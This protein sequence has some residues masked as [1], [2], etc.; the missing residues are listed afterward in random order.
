MAKVNDPIVVRL[1][2]DVTG[3]T[4]SFIDVGT[5]MS[6]EIIEE[7]YG[8][9]F[10][11]TK[12][13]NNDALGAY[14]IGSKTPLAYGNGSF[15]VTTRV[16]G[17]EYGYSIYAGQ[18]S[19]EI[20]LMYEKPTT[21]HNGTEV[22]V[23][24]IE[25]DLSMFTQEIN[26]QLYYFD[27]IIFEGFHELGFKNIN[28]KYT[29]YHGK[30]F[31]YRTD[32]G[33]SLDP[34]IHICIGRV[35]Y[36]INY[37]S[38]GLSS[39]GLN[40]P[41]A[42]KANIGDVDVTMNREALEYNESTRDFIIKKID[43]I[44]K[45]LMSMYEKQCS[46]IQTVEDYL[47]HLSGK[48]LLKIRKK[49]VLNIT[50]IIYNQ[51]KV[52]FANFKYDLLRPILDNT[53]IIECFYFYRTYGQRS[54]KYDDESN[55]VY[56]DTYL[57]VKKL[58]NG[59]SLQKDFVR[60]LIKQSYLASKHKRFYVFIKQPY[61]H[62]MDFMAETIA[63][64]FGT[65][66]TDEVKKEI[67]ALYHE[68]VSY[69]ESYT[70]NYDSIIVPQAFIDLKKQKNKLK[71]YSKKILKVKYGNDFTGK[72]NYDTI[73]IEKLSLFHGKIFYG[74]NDENDKI[75]SSHTIFK[76][77]F[78]DKHIAN[79]YDSKKT[80][81]RG[82]MFLRTNP[83]NLKY[84][85]L[86]RNSYHIDLFPVMMLR[87]KFTTLT[88][89]ITIARI[90]QQ[91]SDIDEYLRHKSFEKIDTEI[92]KANQTVVIEME[93]LNKKVVDFSRIRIEKL[94]SDLRMTIDSDFPA[95]KEID[96]LTNISKKNQPFFS[97]FNFNADNIRH[98]NTVQ[99]L[100]KKVLIK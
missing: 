36:P 27:N 23:P 86:L 61:T 74:T 35:A 17:I 41:I 71:E 85:K 5:G 55:E 90:K 15:F 59:Y 66:L 91:Y 52:K 88:E 14:G 95:Q 46:K 11:S 79:I 77:V 54:S 34:N 8:I 4:L 49:D 7:V 28:N 47:I 96:Y 43:L 62:D 65:T 20:D 72:R 19:P 10:E 38:L 98:N 57:G 45:E 33:N 58:V 37:T 44:K 68:T 67:I 16:N 56:K 18:I 2:R 30:E 63:K 53:K 76:T 64:K 100:L 92:A 84:I 32:E 83:S 78:G 22:K 29:I 73:S 87:R 12:R 99:E 24:I 80:N 97:L 94:L 26:R 1:N 9:I 31:I 6:P 93:K 40:I 39:Y 51:T 89:S 69:V 42:I 81:K 25:K 3:P 50:P 13:D 21:E 75:K 48:S 60:K 70:M 82:I